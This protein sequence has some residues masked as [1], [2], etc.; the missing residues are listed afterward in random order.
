MAVIHFTSNGKLSR[1]P[2]LSSSN[3][4]SPRRWEPLLQLRLPRINTIT[5]V[6]PGTIPFCAVNSKPILQLI[7]QIFAR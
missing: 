1:M 4:S 7:L 2:I 3:I 5:V 6:S